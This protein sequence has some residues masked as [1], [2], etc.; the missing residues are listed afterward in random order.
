MAVLND[1]EEITS[2]FSFSAEWLAGRL[3]ALPI[4]VQEN[5]VKVGR[6]P[7]PKLPSLHRL[8]ILLKP[9]PDRS[10]PDEKSVVPVAR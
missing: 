8:K 5:I 2:I 4:D 7:T 3:L 10:L 1:K 6:S 9:S